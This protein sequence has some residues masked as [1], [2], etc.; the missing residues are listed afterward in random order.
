MAIDI[1]HL[2]IS[3]ICDFDRRGVTLSDEVDVPFEKII[4]NVESD[5][6]AS[7]AELQTLKIEVAK[8][9]PLSKLFRQAGTIINE[10]WTKKEI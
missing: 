3:A 9:C 5:G 6:S 7:E 2:N 10:N 8:Y 4:L 1:G